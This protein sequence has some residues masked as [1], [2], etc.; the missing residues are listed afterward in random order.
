[1]TDG[2]SQRI[3]GIIRFRDLIQMQYR[4]HHGLNLFFFSP[5]VAHQTLFDLKRCIFPDFQAAVGTRKNCH[6][7]GLSHKNRCFGICIKKE[8]LDGNY[9]WLILP[10]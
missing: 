2:S 3:R 8:F 1:M 10:V 7:P 4:L 9:I 5:S 6:P